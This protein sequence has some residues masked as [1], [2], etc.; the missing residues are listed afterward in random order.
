MSEEVDTE[1]Q[2][3]LLAETE[4]KWLSARHASEA[5]DAEASAWY[6]KM[7]EIERRLDP[8][9]AP[10]P[11]QKMLKE[12]ATRMG[13][14]LARHLYGNTKIVEEDLHDSDHQCG[15]RHCWVCQ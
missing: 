14:E 9:S 7:L 5:L 2:K 12:M 3:R 4:A 1:E 15:Q 13:R 8:P 6:K 10:S 11:I